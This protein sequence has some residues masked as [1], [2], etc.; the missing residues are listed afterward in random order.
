MA[1]LFVALGLLLPIG[2]HAAG[3]GKTFL[4][5]HIPVL[6]AGI[7]LDWQWGIAVGAVTPLLS[8]L[9][10]GMPSFAPP[11][12]FMMMVELPVYACMAAVLYRRVRAGALG[13]V[14][15]AALAGRVAYG[16]IGYLLFPLLG[17]PRVGIFYPVTAGLVSGLPG[18]FVQIV[19]IPVIV[20]R[21]KPQL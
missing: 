12:A 18:V 10:T 5:M 11:V 2:L 4:P 3:M 7:Y 16:A 9:L 6:L 19:V 15:G 14:A 17:L 21:F 20:S 8:G 1:G 13:A